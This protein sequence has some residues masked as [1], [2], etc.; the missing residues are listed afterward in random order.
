MLTG[1]FFGLAPVAHLLV[2]NL[3]E[4]L[5]SG[6]GR[7]AGSTGA[8]AFRRVLVVGELALALVLLIGTGLMVRAFWK[9]Q[10]VDIGLDPRRPGHHARQPAARR[11]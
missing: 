1:I 11:L 6:G 2:R 10:Q 8:Q 9:L 4:S 7:T 3:H 5:K